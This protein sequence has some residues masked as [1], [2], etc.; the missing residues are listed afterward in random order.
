MS[1]GD[2]APRPQTGVIPAP[3]PYDDRPLEQAL[4]EA[5]NESGPNPWKAYDGKPVP[6]W[7][8]LPSLPHGPQVMAKWKA[9]AD[10]AVMGV[11]NRMK[12]VVQPE[13]YPGKPEKTAAEVRDNA[14]NECG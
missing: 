10:A 1:D 8:Q 14:H 4:F 7:E 3:L 6:T 5:Y 13:P 9:V 2:D 11:A 12:L